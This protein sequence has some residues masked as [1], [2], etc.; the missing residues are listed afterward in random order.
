MAFGKIGTFIKLFEKKLGVKKSVFK[1]NPGFKRG[2]HRQAKSQ[3]Q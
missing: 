3:W 2:K 1:T